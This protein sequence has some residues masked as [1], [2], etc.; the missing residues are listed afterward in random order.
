MTEQELQAIEDRA[1]AATPGLWEDQDGVD[2]HHYGSIGIGYKHI[3]L[4]NYFNSPDKNIC[5]TREEQIA[6]TAFIAHARMDVSAL[7]AEVRMLQKEL[8]ACEK[9]LP[10]IDPMNFNAMWMGGRR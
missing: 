2:D 3:A 8:A 10:P 7:V 1:N 6:N 9:K 4:C 5:V